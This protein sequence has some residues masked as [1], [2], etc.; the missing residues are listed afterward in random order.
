MRFKLLSDNLL[1]VAARSCVD[2]K[3]CE[4]GRWQSIQ[5]SWQ[6]KSKRIG[7]KGR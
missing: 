5:L 2:V 1:S 4:R 6:D 7:E 3:V